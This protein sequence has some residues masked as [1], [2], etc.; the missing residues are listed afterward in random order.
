MVQVPLTRVTTLK[1]INPESI[2][3]SKYVVYWM[4]SFKRIGYNFA[5]QRAVEWANQL[6]QPL[7]I[8]EPLM[9]DYPMS[10][11]RFHKFTLE[12]MKEVD[13]EVSKTKAY[14]YPFVEQSA[15]ESEGLLSE[16]SKKA[17]VVITDDYPTYFV[18]Q[19]T[20]KAS[21]EIPSRYELIDSNGLVPIRLSEKENVRAHDFRRYLNKNLEDFKFETQLEDPLDELIKDFDNSMISSVEKTWKPFD[22]KN[23]DIDSFLDQLEIDK[24]V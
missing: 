18:P 4:I 15:K 1:D 5:L 7:L 3:E 10:S 9:L 8:L 14:Y 24:S 21:G 11:I 22:F 19:M 23:T 16:I 20:A 6:S 17:S 12:G 2:S 13:D